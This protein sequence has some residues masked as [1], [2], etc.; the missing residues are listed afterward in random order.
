MHYDEYFSNVFLNI[1]NIAIL[2]TWQKRS[3]SEIA[4]II[5]GQSPS[6]K[7]YTTDTNDS[8]LVQGNADLHLGQIVPRVWTKQITKMARSNAL[9]L[10]V[11]APVGQVAITNSCVVLG[12]G[13]AGI[14]GPAILYYVFQYLNTS[15]YWERVSS[16]STF[17]AINSNDLENIPV[18]LPNSVEQDK[19]FIA[20]KKIDNLIAV[21]QRNLQYVKLCKIQFKDHQILPTE[22]CFST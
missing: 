17:D 16:G 6:S 9:I 21:N 5:M 19:I 7:N 20:L 8:I 14:T 3:L 12:R 15:H 22:R 2:N 13:V 4:S 10:T 1:C 18:T 11:R